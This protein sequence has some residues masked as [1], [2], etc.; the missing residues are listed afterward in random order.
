MLP[1]G[2]RAVDPKICPNHRQVQELAV[3]MR[4]TSFLEEPAGHAHASDGDHARPA[5]PHE[6]DRRPASRWSARSARGRDIATTLEEWDTRT[7]TCP[8]TKSSIVAWTRTA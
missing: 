3:V 2:V 7:Q 6:A 1:A 8:G 4:W 5:A